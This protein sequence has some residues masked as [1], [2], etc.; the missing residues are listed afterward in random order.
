MIK[1]LRP[2]SNGQVTT[3][4]P[5]LH[6]GHSKMY[7][8]PSTVF[9]KVDEIRAGQSL[10]IAITRKQGGIGDVLMTLPAVKAIAKKYSANITYGTDTDYMDG[11]LF[12]VLKGISY[13]KEVVPF[14]LINEEYYHAIL[15]LTC[16]CVAHEQL[17][18]VPINRID[19]FARYAGIPLEDKTI[20]YMVTPEERTWALEFV[21]SRYLDRTPLVFMQPCSSSLHRDCP[22]PIV[23]KVI[24]GL[25]V[26]G[27]KILFTRSGYDSSRTDWNYNG[28]FPLKDLSIRQVAA[29]ME[30]CQL[31]ICPDSAMLHLASAQHLPTLALFGPSDPR[32]RI[33]YHPEAVAYWPGG[34]LRNYPIWYDN[35]SNANMGWQLMQ[36]D[37]IIQTAVDILTGKGILDTPDLV[38]FG[39]YPRYQQ[40]Q[41]I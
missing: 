7:Q 31:V 16:P 3:A 17:G 13:I 2:T 5:L 8:K 12:E 37:T 27:L 26:K 30:Q 33:N 38:H 39:S 18:A 23:K 34:R 24:E 36:P 19:L 11:A 15:D 21:Q 14:R 20:D 25:L 35:A 9:K 40:P 4:Q 22:A 10:N 28:G 6:G 32:A 1:G 41:L 29:L